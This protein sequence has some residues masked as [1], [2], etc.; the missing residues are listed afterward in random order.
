MAEFVDIG[1][2]E[3]GKGAERRK[4][5]GS[6]Q[7]DASAARLPARANE[8]TLEEPLYRLRFRQEQALRGPVLVSLSIETKHPELSSPSPVFCLDPLLPEA[9][10]RSPSTLQQI[11]QPDISESARRE[12][13][14]VLVKELAQNKERS[15][16]V[17]RPVRGL[18]RVRPAN[19]GRD[20]LEP[21]FE[22]K[23]AVTTSF[24]D[25]VRGLARKSISVFRNEMT[26]ASFTVTTNGSEVESAEIF[27]EPL[28]IRWPILDERGE[29]ATA[30]TAD[31]AILDYVSMLRATRGAMWAVSLHHIAHELERRQRIRLDEKGE[32]YAEPFLYEFM[33]AAPDEQLWGDDTSRTPVALALA[34]SGKN[35][36]P[37][38]LIE[39]RVTWIGLEAAE[40]RALPRSI[41]LAGYSTSGA[42]YHLQLSAPPAFDRAMKRLH[43][44]LM[45][46]PGWGKFMHAVER[47]CAVPGLKIACSMKDPAEH[48][49]VA[50]NSLLEGLQRSAPE[51]RVTRGAPFGATFPR[52]GS[53]PERIEGYLLGKSMFSAEFVGP[54]PATTWLVEAA[55]DENLS[56]RVSCFNALG[57]SISAG[58]P[59]DEGLTGK[60]REAL[61]GLLAAART[62]PHLVPQSLEEIPGVMLRSDLVPDGR[63]NPAYLWLDRVAAAWQ[64]ELLAAGALRSERDTNRIPWW[65]DHL[66]RGR[67]SLSLLPA[68]GPEF[69]WERS[70]SVIVGPGGVE[71]VYLSRGERSFLGLLRGAYVSAPEGVRY[72]GAE[73]V[74]TLLRLASSSRTLRTQ[75]AIED[76]IEEA[77][78]HLVL[79]RGIGM[80]Q[81]DPLR[82]D[83]D[84][85][86][87][88]RNW[89]GKVFGV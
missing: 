43:K 78:P 27:A 18:E 89:V 59:L 34:P 61:E 39:G 62:Q 35:L 9:N 75:Q 71:G 26:V 4:A 52:G 5:E 28:N 32:F 2:E 42:E 14:G 25:F 46:A 40:S 85:L 73:D 81:C 36:K 53:L 88:V 49:P 56:G 79:R 67:V 57:G 66:E 19:P 20:E 69:S 22:V 6:Q 60:R 21:T 13:I 58:L 37:K 68:A 41:V 44:D 82:D 23:A 31:G 7:Q 38:S 30:K 24:A 3:G 1:R 51:V 45:S 8:L 77:L 17:Q 55:L 50:I 12:A 74:S 11:I 47:V 72:M 76:T 84:L 87:R 80:R 29:H 15:E 33:A 16:L 64:R 10:R 54:T 63:F 65:V 83:R 70:H 86:Q 48:F